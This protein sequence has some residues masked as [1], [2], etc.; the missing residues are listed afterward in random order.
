MKVNPCILFES[1][2]DFLYDSFFAHRLF[3]FCLD[4]VVRFPASLRPLCRENK[5]DDQRENDDEH[6]IE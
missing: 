3:A 5:M 4:L 1:G 6:Q 2:T